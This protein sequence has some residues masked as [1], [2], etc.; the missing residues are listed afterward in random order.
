MAI[1]NAI[2]VR[3]RNSLPKNEPLLRLAHATDGC[4]R[5]YDIEARTKGNPKDFAGAVRCA[6]EL[7]GKDLP[8]IEVHTQEEQIDAT[9]GDEAELRQ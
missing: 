5:R 6:V 4:N 7:V 9:P 8:L 2:F 3:D 1:G